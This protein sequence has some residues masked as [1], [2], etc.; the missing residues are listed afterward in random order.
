MGV[1]RQGF[2][3]WLIV[4]KGVLTVKVTTARAPEPFTGLLARGDECVTN[5][6]ILVAIAF[7]PYGFDPPVNP[8]R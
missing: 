6:S 7:L 5:L 8:Y 3:L 2:T 4:E 1:F